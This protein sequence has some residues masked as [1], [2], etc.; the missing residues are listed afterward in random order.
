MNDSDLVFFRT[1]GHGFTLGTPEQNDPSQQAKDG[2]SRRGPREDNAFLRSR[3][4]EVNEFSDS[5]GCTT[6]SATLVLA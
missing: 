3:E 6:I 4:I 5:A 1:S 2:L